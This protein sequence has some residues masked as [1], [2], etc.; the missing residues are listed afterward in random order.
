MSVSLERMQEAAKKYPELAGDEVALRKKVLEDIAE[1]QKQEAAGGD[2]TTAALNKLDQA[3]R[4]ASL[5]L[6]KELIVPLSQTVGPALLKAGEAFGAMTSENVARAKSELGAIDKIVN[7]AKK[8]AEAPVAA[9]T[10]PTTTA[11]AKPETTA[12]TGTPKPY[13][14]IPGAKPISREFGSLGMTGK[15]FEDFGE[16]TLAM[17]HGKET[18][19]TPGQLSGLISKATARPMAVPEG[20]ESLVAGMDSKLQTM[21]QKME[22]A[23]LKMIGDM[24][25]PDTSMMFD[26]KVMTDIAGTLEKLNMTMTQ[27]A[28]NTAEQVGASK[29]QIRATQGLSGDLFKGM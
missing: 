18:V 21:A 28:E 7:D 15:L 13:E 26:P 10:K 6:T 4:D 11:P 19:M 27:V 8:K 24:P 20:M 14:Y 29:K 9:P 16:G 25:R 12:P 5:A 23:S 17:L 2:K 22:A 1:Q 3:S